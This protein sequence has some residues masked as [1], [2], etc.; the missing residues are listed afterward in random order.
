[1]VKKEKMKASIPKW[2]GNHPFSPEEK[3]PVVITKDME[4]STLYGFQG[5]QVESQIFVSTDKITFSDWTLPPGA[6]IEPP[7]LHN[8]G[9]EV[10]Y[11]LEGD[12]VAF[13]PE[14]GEAYQLHAGDTLLIPQGTRHQIYNFT[15]KSVLTISCIP[16]TILNNL[17]YVKMSG[18]STTAYVNVYL[19]ELQWLPS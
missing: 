13:N 15:E 5:T 14:K 9:D 16:N 1:M 12:P 8:Y 18:Y 3:K 11:F 7:G 6:R 4:L 17:Y 2:I 10:Y 19:K